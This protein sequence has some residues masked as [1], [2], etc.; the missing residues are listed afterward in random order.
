MPAG[1]PGLL[2]W[3]VVNEP[4]TGGATNL[5]G[6]PAGPR[7]TFVKWAVKYMQS[8][9]KTPTT[10]GVAEV[11]SLATVGSAVDILSFH[12]YHNTWEDGLL[13]TQSALGFAAQFNKPVFNSETG[14]IARAN[15][16]DQTVE[17]AVSNGIGYV[18]PTSI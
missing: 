5:P 10:V 3:D 18:H 9:T 17:M 6:E 11:G 8:V 1:T 4:E 13:A 2:L 7:W 16:F 12:S 15:A 14:C